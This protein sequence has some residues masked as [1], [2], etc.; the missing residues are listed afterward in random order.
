MNL[1]QL[2]A[3]DSSFIYSVQR[4]ILKQALYI[5]LVYCIFEINLEY[6]GTRCKI[7]TQALYISLV[8]C[9]FAIGYIFI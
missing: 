5:S 9:I 4:K 6:I 3:T 8:Y 1:W 2:T 7:L